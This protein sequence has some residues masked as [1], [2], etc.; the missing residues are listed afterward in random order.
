[1]FQYISEIYIHPIAFIGLQIVNKHFQSDKSKFA[2][3]KSYLL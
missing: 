1:M 2:T 3:N